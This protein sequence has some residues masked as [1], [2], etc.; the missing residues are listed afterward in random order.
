[1]ILDRLGDILI[2]LGVGML[3]TSCAIMTTHTQHE[4]DEDLLNVPYEGYEMNVNAIH[5]PLI[6][7]H[8]EDDK[9]FCSGFVIDNNY[10]ITA[11]H[12]VQ[13]KDEVNIYNS[14]SQD[15]EIVA[16][17]AGFNSR[18]DYAILRGDF[19]RFGKFQIETEILKVFSRNA[20][21][22]ACGFALGQRRASCYSA[23]LLGMKYTYISA[24]SILFPGMSGGPVIDRSTNTVVALNSY[25]DDGR[26]GL[27]PLVGILATFGIESKD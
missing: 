6:R 10:A 21:L 7:L 11:A 9:F 8:N 13:D 26:V 19:S 25:V 1:M 4:K 3:L 17:T 16:E 23:T 27:T 2:G 12:C 22:I 14:L 24:R 20:N 18:M 5:Q 15:T